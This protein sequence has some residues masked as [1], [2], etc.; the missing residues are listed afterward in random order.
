[1]YCGECGYKNPPNGNFCS[2][3]GELLE[4]IGDTNG[5]SSNGEK[6]KIKSFTAIGSA[7]AFICFFLPWM[8]VSCGAHEAQS[9]G[10]DLAQGSMKV[11]DGIETVTESLD[12]LLGEIDSNPVD[13]WNLSKA[14]DYSALYLI[15]VLGLCGLAVYKESQGGSLIATGSGILGMIGLFLVF[16]K[17]NSFKDA[18]A[19]NTLGMVELKYQIGYFGE[20]IG[21]GLQTYFGYLGYKE[22]DT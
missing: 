15:P 20:W 2:N 6:T 3:C 11:S 22:Y 12:D 7:I 13:E 17:V 8:A 10:N 16:S 5:G 19:A 9:S 21:F 18:I 1:M 4:M 14:V